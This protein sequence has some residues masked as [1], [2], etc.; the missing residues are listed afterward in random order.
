MGLKVNG[1]DYR[2]W[3]DAFARMLPTPEFAALGAEGGL[4]SFSL[5]GAE[6]DA[7]VKKAVRE[8]AALARDF[9][10]VEMTASSKQS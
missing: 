10:L 9:N 5:T 3:V 6:L 2:F 1:A 8:Y 4:Y 7:Y